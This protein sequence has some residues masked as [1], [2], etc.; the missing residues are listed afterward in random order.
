VK[1]FRRIDQHTAE[2]ELSQ[3]Y[4]AR[5]E[6]DMLP[7]LAIHSWS[8]HKSKGRVYA[9][10]QIGGRTVYMHRFLADAPSDPGLV[11]DHRNG[12]GLDNRRSNLRLATRRQNAQNS[13]GAVGRRLSAT[14][15]VSKRQHPQRPWRAYIYDLNGRFKH[16]GYF[17]TEEEAVATRLKAEKELFGEFAF[18][19][20]NAA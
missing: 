3:G 7:Q 9:K 11:I 19:C 16:L 8:V 10:T 1:T 18:Q 12:D 13:R 20:R 6:T 4:W 5:V 15:G 14:R 17:A 2:I